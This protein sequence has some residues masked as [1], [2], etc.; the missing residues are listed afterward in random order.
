MG[1]SDTK[2]SSHT[3]KGFLERIG[4]RKSKKP[5]EEEHQQ[6]EDEEGEESQHHQETIDDPD[7]GEVIA[8]D[9]DQTVTSSSLSSSTPARTSIDS[10]RSVPAVPHP[11]MSS[12]Q[13]DG[14]SLLP[15]KGIPV[16]VNACVA[17]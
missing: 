3:K 13:R 10:N 9:T 1:L 14:T 6:H 16:K 2:L 12:N 8:D 15:H 4:L 5:V 11:S 17:V 7:E